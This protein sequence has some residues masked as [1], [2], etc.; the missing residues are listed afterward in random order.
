MILLRAHRPG[1]LSTIQDLG[2][3][4]YLKEGLPPS[5]ALDELAFRAANLLVGNPIEAAALELTLWGGE[6]ECLAG[7]WAA[8]AGAEMK[9]RLNGEPIGN[10][11]SLRLARGDRLDLGNCEKGCRAY[12]ALE[13]GIEGTLVLGSRSTYL[14]AGLGGLE[15]RA[16]RAGDLLLA[17]TGQERGEQSSSLWEEKRLGQ[18]KVPRALEQSSIPIY[19]N[20]WTLRVL[21]GPQEERFPAELRAVFSGD[22]YRVSERH[23]RMGVRLE[24][25]SLAPPEGSD[26]LSQA[27]PPGAVQVPA[28]G[29]PI[30]MLA[31][32][33]TTG[34]Y[35][36]IATVLGA[37]LW[38]AGQLK[39]GDMARFQPVTLEEGRAAWR[40]FRAYLSQ[41]PVHICPL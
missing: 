28:D 32:R 39:A 2:R 19:P 16:V 37:D 20:P 1:F 14:R 7:G 18:P 29:Q 17:R 15:G 25:P 41:L 26:L 31:D 12:L 22:A 34:G 11:R 21:W 8:I 30:M 6:W 38:R 33:Q 24:G 13:G 35:A 36:V 10:W 5:G 40:D 4:G 27:I 23:D 9:G 3:P